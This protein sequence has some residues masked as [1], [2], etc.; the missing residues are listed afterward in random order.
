MYKYKCI[1]IYYVMLYHMVNC[2]LFM[3]FYQDGNIFQFEDQSSRD[4]KRCPM[5]PVVIIS[6]VLFSIYPLPET[7]KQAVPDQNYRIV[8]APLKPTVSF[9]IITR[10]SWSLWANFQNMSIT[11]L[12]MKVIASITRILPI[13]CYHQDR[14][15]TYR[16]RNKGFS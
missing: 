4:F 12:A 1:H 2:Q 11:E 8:S 15:I 9:L 5:Y 3:A 7:L 10:K 16:I 13:T 6:K 14:R